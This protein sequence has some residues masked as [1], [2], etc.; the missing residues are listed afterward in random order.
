MTREMNKR[1]V[2]ILSTYAS[3]PS[4]V[5]ESG[6]RRT[7]GRQRTSLKKTSVEREGIPTVNPFLKVREAFGG[8]FQRR[9]MCV[10]IDKQVNK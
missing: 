5:G 8:G 4:R 10:I 1:V 3:V 6:C 9:G 7:L 2:R